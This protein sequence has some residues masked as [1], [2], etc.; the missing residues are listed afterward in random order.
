[1]EMERAVKSTMWKFCAILGLAED[2]YY[3]K[4]CD[5]NFLFVKISAWKL[6]LFYILKI[7]LADKKYF[8]VT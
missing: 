7:T 4:K 8:V 3:V 6:S 1:M 2:D 5:G